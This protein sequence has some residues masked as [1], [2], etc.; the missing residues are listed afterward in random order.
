M[1]VSLAYANVELHPPTGKDVEKLYAWRND[2]AELGL[3]KAGRHPI[4]LDG[5]RAELDRF[6]SEHVYLRLMIHYRNE[7]VGTVYAYDAN[8]VH[9][10][11]YMAI[12]IV[13]KYRGGLRSIAPRAWGLLADYLFKAFPFRKL[14]AEVYGFNQLSLRTLRSAGLITEAQVPEHFF[15]NGDYYDMFLLALYRHQLATTVVKFL[16]KRG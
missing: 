6:E 5:F 13:P 16:P 14:Y 11:T 12:Y 7:T 8:L 15:W 3:W 9:G 1:V 4:D 10:W 2:L